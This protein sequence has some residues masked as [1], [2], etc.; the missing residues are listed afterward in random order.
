MKLRKWIAPISMVLCL[1]LLPMASLACGSKEE[2]ISM[3]MAS[4][5]NT[6]LA[7]YAIREGIVTSD[8][9]KVSIELGNDHDIQMRSGKYPMGVMNTHGFAMAVQKENLQ[10]VAISSVISHEG[11]LER[12]GVNYMFARTSSS[13]SSPFDLKGKKIGLPQPETA[14]SNLCVLALLQEEY[15]LDFDDFASLSYHP[16]AVLWSSLERG[17]LDAVLIGK[18]IGVQALQEPSFKVIWNVDDA[19]FDK[20]GAPLVASILVVKADFYE[21]NRATVKIV[22]DLL[23]ES[24]TYGAAHI[25]ELAPLYA[26]EYGQDADFYKV[27]YNEHSSFKLTEIKDGVYDSVMGLFSLVMARGHIDSMLDPMVVFRTP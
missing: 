5:F 16:E 6:W 14:A 7:T 2:V 4:S 24:A 10:V 26:A 13:I 9:V 1:C 11:A 8:K 27:I 18:N 22:Y 17:D 21:Q 15:G 25:D 3:P 20:F 23:T 12:E 19:F